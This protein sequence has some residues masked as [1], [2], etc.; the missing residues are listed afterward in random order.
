LPEF[1]GY[2]L[3]SPSYWRFVKESQSGIAVPNFNASKMGRIPVPMV[4]IEEQERMVL[5]LDTLWSRLAAAEANLR[6][7]K[8]GL[9]RFGR[10]VLQSA[11]AGRLVPNEAD[12]AHAGEFQP[13]TELLEEL[14]QQRRR[15]GSGTQGGRAAA[16]ARKRSGKSAEKAGI[17]YA[18]GGPPGSSLLPEGWCWARIDEIATVK[19]GHPFK[20]AEFKSLGVR[21]LRGQEIEPGGLRWGDARHWDAQDL[22]RYS[23]FLVQPGDIVLGMDRPVVAAGLK[24][25]RVTPADAPALLVQ[26]VAR[27]RAVDATVQDYLYHAMGRPDFVADVLRGQTGTQLPHISHSSV[28]G[29]LLPLPPRGEMG[30]IC[31]ALSAAMG[32][33]K[34]LS[35]AIERHLRDL[36]RL[37]LSLLTQFCAKSDG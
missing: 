12:L 5:R 20:S 10:S 3:Q 32:L 18:S 16:D 24:L 4:G 2:V 1:L 30:R 37:R 6:G 19:I 36:Q 26:R 28:P 34:R 31:V 13:A 25:A 33:W 9:G 8:E 27:I 22:E 11:F 17:G 23:D 35:S 29:H 7:A 14:L 21:L 15:Q